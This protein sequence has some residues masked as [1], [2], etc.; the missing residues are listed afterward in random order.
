M[1]QRAI[2]SSDEVVMDTDYADDMA[3]LDNCKDGLQES[4]DQLCKYAAQAGLMVNAKKTEAMAIAKNTSQR[5]LHTEAESVGIT[6]GDTAIHQVSNFTYL[7][8]N[9][10]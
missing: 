3:L 6:V 8:T 10:R 2:T 4:T 5:P 9:G 1:L 7:G